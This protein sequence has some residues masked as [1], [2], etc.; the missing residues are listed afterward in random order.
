[1]I[2]KVLGQCVGMRFRAYIREE[3]GMVK[4]FDEVLI[5]VSSTHLDFVMISKAG[6]F[7]VQ[8][9]RRMSGGHSLRK[10]ELKIKYQ[11]NTL[12][13]IEWRDYTNFIFT[14]IN[15]RDRVLPS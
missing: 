10:S 5:E 15:N 14:P 4:A 8:K 6:P 1:M 12:V 2:G 7:R 11:S 9:K 3:A 13:V